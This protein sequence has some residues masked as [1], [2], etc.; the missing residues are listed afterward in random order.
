MENQY[1]YKADH[2]EAK[3]SHHK[4]QPKPSIALKVGIVLAV[5]AQFAVVIG[6]C[7]A[8]GLFFI[9]TAS[10]TV[11]H[12][13]DRP[14]ITD[15]S[16]LPIQKETPRAVLRTSEGSTFTDISDIVDHVMPSV[17]SITNLSVQ[18]VQ[19]FFGRISQFESEGAGSG[20]II[21]E[22]EDEILIV[23]N[24]HVVTGYETLTVALY[25]GTTVS[26]NV[27]GSNEEYDIAVIAIL[28]DSITEDTLS[29]IT[30]A[31]IGDSNALRVG[32]PAIAI[33]NAL[34]FGQS[35]TAGVISALNRP[36]NFWGGSDPDSDPG[37]LLIQT[38]AAINPGNSGGALVN[39]RGEVIGINSQKIAGQAI[40]G[41][42][43]AIP[44][45]DVADIITELMNQET[46]RRVPEENRGF[47]GI[48]GDNVSQEIASRY[49]MPVGVFI[50][51]VHEG[52]GAADAGLTRANIIT[53]LN[54]VKITDMTSLL[55]ELQFHRIGETVELT[56]EIPQAHGKYY[57]EVVTVTLGARIVP[58]NVAE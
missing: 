6:M 30:I 46:R 26:A 15:A 8:I 57:T 54:E 5:I 55:N 42:G 1:N 50:I 4:A 53:K 51:E 17:V 29:K 48:T 7:A 47:L 35:V 14:T 39:Q 37:V 3:N 13:D 24:Y 52:G 33:G 32:E 49:G 11:G 23:T 34:G 40:E 10:F 22:T 12:T 45:S 36:S 28:K 58:S 43:Y 21:A 31:Q 16:E 41:V 19:D 38:D 27:K 44:V 9:R 56:V 25:D 18:Q 20:I 2:T